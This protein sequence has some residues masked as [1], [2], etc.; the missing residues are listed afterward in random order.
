MTPAERAEMETMREENRQLRALRLPPER[1][2]SDFGFSRTERIVLASLMGA[3]DI[4]PR[5]YLIDCIVLSRARSQGIEPKTVDV[6]LWRLRQKLIGMG[7][8][9][10][11]ETIWGEGWR[12]RNGEVKARLTDFFAATKK[13]TT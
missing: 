4:C 7:F 8:P 3:D 2:Y 10:V 6:V 1:Q 11:I 9:G 5:D 12:I 13:G